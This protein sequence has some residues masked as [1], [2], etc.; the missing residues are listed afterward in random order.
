MPVYVQEENRNGYD[1]GYFTVAE[2]IQAAV[3]AHNAGAA[4]YIFHTAAGFD[5][6][7]SSFFDNLDSVERGVVDGLSAAVF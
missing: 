1:G 7:S 6:S 5:L 4:G 3:E 2:L